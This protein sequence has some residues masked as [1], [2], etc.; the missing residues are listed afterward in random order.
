MRVLKIGGGVARRLDL[1]DL[2]GDVIVHGASDQVDELCKRLGIEIRRLVSPSGV[3]FRHTPDEVLEVYLMAAMKLN[4]EI[5]AHLQGRG[6]KAIGVSGMDLGIVRAR[7]KRF[8]KAVV[9]GRKF[10]LRDDNSGIIEEVD[11]R[12]IRGLMNL[13]IPVI[14]PIAISEENRPLNIDGD[15]MA[16]EIAVSLSA[17]ELVFLSDLPFLVDGRAV[18]RLSSSEVRGLLMHAR[19]GM[20]RKLMMA[21]EALRRGVGMVVIRG[22][23]GETV[24]V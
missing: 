9:D 16:T 12:R 21:E 15:R 14:A 10:V 20:R 7:R 1:L 19:G 18:D 23:D 11:S 17:D 24:I 13:G 8:V 4:K 22:L 5:V 6:M 3:E 2:D